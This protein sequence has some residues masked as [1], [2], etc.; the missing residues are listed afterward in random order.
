[1]AILSRYSVTPIRQ[2]SKIH[3]QLWKENFYEKALRNQS[4]RFSLTITR[5]R[6]Y[7]MTKDG[8]YIQHGGEEKRTRDLGDEGA[9][10]KTILK[11]NKAFSGDQHCQYGVSIQSFGDCLLHH[12]G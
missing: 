12:Q 11:C 4:L 5:A 2:T 7:R 1:M 6:K 3:L 10:C 8:W 9:D